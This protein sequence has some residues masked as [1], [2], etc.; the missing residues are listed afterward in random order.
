MLRDGAGLWCSFVEEMSH[1][2]L[3]ARNRHMKQSADTP[4]ESSTDFEDAVRKAGDEAMKQLAEEMA[5]G[6]FDKEELKSP[7]EA[8]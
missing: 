6:A 2:V 4:R 1:R 8:E 3:L 7:N 5:A